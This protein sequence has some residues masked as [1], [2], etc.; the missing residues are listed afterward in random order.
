[1]Y[2]GY[3]VAQIFQKHEIKHVFTLTGGHIAPILIG[4]KK[5]GIEVID[6]RHEVT[7]VF[8]ADAY[9]RLSDKVGVAIVTAGP[10][11]TNI[12]T[13]VKNAQMAQSPVVII[14]GAPPM[15]Y[16]GKDE[17]QDIDQIA[18]MKSLVKWHVV[19]KSYKQIAK[20]SEAFYKAKEGL[21]GP[22]FIEM[23][24]DLLWPSSM[25][26]GGYTEGA[27]KMPK[28][29][30][31]QIQKKYI[32]FFLNKMMNGYKDFK[33]P[34]PKKLQRKEVSEGNLQKTTFLLENSE[35]L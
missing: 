5:L 34:E 3:F 8:A 20:V 11:I 32:V 30:L 31:G 18:I 10:G 21:P 14:G 19:I 16:K 22:V 27:N 2:G 23:S 12:V 15:I 33:V 26:I 13:A 7:T 4:C 35:I 17:L 29:L 28:N 9:S 24:L 1:M 6:V 25:T